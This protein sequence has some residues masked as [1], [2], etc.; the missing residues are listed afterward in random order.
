MIN[1]KSQANY[2]FADIGDLHLVLKEM[3]DCWQVS[4][5]FRVHSSTSGKSMV[6]PTSVITKFEKPCDL[7]QAQSLTDAYMEKFIDEIVNDFKE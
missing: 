7:S 2:Y 4:M 1:W 6:R 5:G 3:R